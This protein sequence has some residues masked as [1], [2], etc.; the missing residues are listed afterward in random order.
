[1]K[2]KFLFFL[3]LLILFIAY[4]LINT[5]TFRSK[6]LDIQPIQPVAID[7]KSIHN[8]TEA[9]K[10]KTISPENLQDFDSLQ[11]RAFNSFLE[12][13]YPLLDSILSKEV[14]NEFSHLYK[15]Q[16]SNNSLKPIL[17]LAHIDVVPVIKENL[18]DWK[19]SP[20]EG[21][22]KNDT[23]WGRGT[24]DDKISVIGILEATE[25][26]LSQDYVPQRTIYI[27]FG[28][29]EE[30]GGELGAKTISK[31]LQD[32]NIEV[33][34]I[35]DEGGS[36]TQ[37]LIPDIEKDVALIGI[38]E[39]GYVS[40]KLST[41]IEGGHSSMPSKE[42]SIDV[43]ATAISKLKSNPLPTKITKPIEGF[44]DYVGPE[45]PFVNKV[46]FANKNIFSS[47]I[48]DI[49]SASGSGNALVRTTTAPTIF[50]SGVKDNI[51]PQTASATI[52]FRTL[53]DDTI[54][55]IIAHVSNVVNDNRVEVN[56][57]E[58]FNS[59]A[60]K[61]SPT[62]T[63]G[64]NII[65]KTINEI[66]QE[67][68]TSPYLVVGGTDARHYGNLSNNIYRFSPIKLNKT[69]LKSFHGLN[70]RVGVDDF[71]TAIRFYIQLI[72]NGSTNQ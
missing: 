63:L 56:V 69:N 26:L 37:K 38:A 23:I 1:M 14:F 19:V 32:K 59:E 50:N 6:Q 51:I 68:Y 42:T 67:T 34:F 12:N 11:F 20:F 58:T 33:E 8:F 7:D 44:I 2:K 64:F 55:S 43:L 60:S 22:I 30:I 61:V 41:K 9:L 70:E 17:L 31:Y 28:H 72:K 36:I 39:K 40:L 24:I 49:Y 53:P 21:L 5:L 29:D 4:L 71:K 45:M 10:I 18:Q 54:E 48:T 35:L 15:W 13:T 65:N 66:F 25:M 3:A 62:E 57:A 46:V 27:A 52:N 47:I 16:G